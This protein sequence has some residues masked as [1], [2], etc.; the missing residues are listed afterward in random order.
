MERE[1]ELDHAE[2]GGEV[3]AGSG[4]LL[5][6]EGPNL[7]GELGEACLVER[8]QVGGGVDRLENSHSVLT[9]SPRHE[10]RQLDAES[11]ARAARPDRKSVVEG[12]GAEQ[13]RV[14]Y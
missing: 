5:D 1:R 4:C 7:G 9:L 10:F 8:F 2:V 14:G 6:K 3:S 12:K 13:R 11:R